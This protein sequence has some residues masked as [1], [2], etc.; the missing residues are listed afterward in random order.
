MFKWL[1]L[2]EKA[3]RLQEELTAV[4]LKKEQLIHSANRVKELEV[5]LTLLFFRNHCYTMRDISA[6][7]ICDVL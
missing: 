7:V 4:T 3:I 2:S 1:S 6:V 5:L